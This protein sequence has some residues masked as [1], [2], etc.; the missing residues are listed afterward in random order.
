MGLSD[1]FARL[2][3]GRR[4]RDV[5]SF[6]QDLG[7]AGGIRGQ[8]DR[9]FKEVPVEKIVGSVGRWQNLRSDFFYKSG[10]ITGRFTRV[11]EAMEQ[12]KT[13]PPLEL[14]KVKGPDQPSA[15]Y[16]VDGNHRVAMAKKLGVDSLDAHVVEY[17]V[18]GK[19]DEERPSDASAP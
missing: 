3:L 12:G 10:K 9:G 16:V 6:D 11:G 17:K 13:L 8:V 2:G 7:A 19:V 4:H 5:R 1:L 15:Y 18:D 14:Y